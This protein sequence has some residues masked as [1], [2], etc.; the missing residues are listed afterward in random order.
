MSS[1]Y[2]QLWLSGRDKGGL[3]DLPSN[4][5]V[6]LLGQLSFAL[7]FCELLHDLVAFLETHGI[8]RR[9]LSRSRRDRVRAW[10]SRGHEEVD[11]WISQAKDM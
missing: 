10:R 8:A 3:H 11:G 1:C 6:L 4:L 5:P 2:E 9:S 7:Y